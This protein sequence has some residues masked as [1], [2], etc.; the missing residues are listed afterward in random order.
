MSD[1]RQRLDTLS[2]T[3][4]PPPGGEERPTGW[5]VLVGTIISNE[6]VDFHLAFSWDSELHTY[7]QDAIDAGLRKLGHDDFNIGYVED[8]CL[9]WFGWMRDQFPEEDYV[10]AAKQFGWTTLV[11]SPAGG[12]EGDDTAQPEEPT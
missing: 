12:E 1:T 11:P 3:P 10:N 2:P 5:V 7:Q 9:L 4:P 6:T 8:G